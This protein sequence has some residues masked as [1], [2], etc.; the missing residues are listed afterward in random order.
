MRL[1]YRTPLTALLIGAAGAAQAA[2]IDGAGL[3]AWWGLPFAGMLLSIALLPLLLPKVW[4]PHFGKITAGWVLLLLLPFAATQGLGLA[5]L[6][7][8]C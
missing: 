5:R 2:E 6:A 7:R 4:H 3:S 1:L 8:R